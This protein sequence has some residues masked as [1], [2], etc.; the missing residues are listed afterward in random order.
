MV[1]RRIKQL[2]VVVV[3]ALWALPSAMA[4]GPHEI[5]LL[6][7]GGEPDSIEVAKEYAR[8]RQIPD[9]NIVRLRLPAWKPGQ[10]PVMAPQDFTRLIWTPAN[11]AAKAR[12]IDDHILAW[13]YSTHF[14]IRIDMQPPI[15][16][17]GLTFMRNRMPKSKDV[18]D[19]TYESPIFAG[20][21]KP[22][23]NAYG[24]QSFD[25]MKQLL[26][27]EMP[28][29]CM[30][31]GYIGPRGNSKAQVLGCLQTGVSSDATSPTGSIYFIKS[32]NIRSRCRH[33]QFPSAAAGLKH[34]GIKSTIGEAFPEGRQDVMGIMMGSAIVT[35]TKV[36]RF[37]PGSMAEHLTSCAAFFDNENQTK[38]SQWIAAGVTASA[39]AVWEPLSLWSKFPNA[40]FYNHY[41]SGCTMIES[42]YQ[43]IKCPLQMLIIGEPLAAPWAPPASLRIEGIR[44]GELVEAPRSIDIRVETV[45][46]ISFSRL[47]YLVDGRIRGSGTSFTLD[48]AGLTPGNHA[49][50][51]VAYRT[52]FVR[53][54]AFDV[55]VFRTE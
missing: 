51:A 54:Q 37:L 20:P 44:D 2:V 30:A 17:Q 1:Y 8:L 21:D 49:L 18:G 16:L 39:G 7:N 6:A 46:G 23:G 26:R 13:V 41:A 19:G 15:S 9:A 22:G 36:G 12:G 25:T 4:L 34:K 3:S 43:S 27:E 10:P 11:Q 33:W 48:P 14:P 28:L 40:R 55:K 50:R 42:F 45:R 35:P 32:D 24:P 53:S 5:L 47:A 31:L 29:P 52:G 38:I